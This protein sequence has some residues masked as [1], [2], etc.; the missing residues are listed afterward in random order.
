MLQDAAGLLSRGD[1]L[2]GQGEGQ[3]AGL[4]GVDLLHL[5]LSNPGDVGV[6]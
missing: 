6:W 1:N 5:P 4:L 2:A 3:N